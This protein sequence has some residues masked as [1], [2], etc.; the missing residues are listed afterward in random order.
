MCEIVTC[1]TSSIRYSSA[2]RIRPKEGHRFKGGSYVIS[3]ML[4]Q[5]VG[6]I[7]SFKYLLASTFESCMVLVCLCYY[8]CSLKYTLKLEKTVSNHSLIMQGVL[9]GTSWSKEMTPLC[10]ELHRQYLHIRSI[11]CIKIFRCKHFMHK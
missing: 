10:Q 1:K 8:M 6:Y 7:L 3:T 11:S 5:C 9:E 4:C 2:A